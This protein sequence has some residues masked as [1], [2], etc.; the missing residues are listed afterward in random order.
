[1]RR[2][3]GRHS[4]GGDG[5]RASVRG[6]LG[7]DPAIPAGALSARVVITIDADVDRATAE[8]L[9]RWAVDHCPVTESLSR[10]VPLELEVR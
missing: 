10:A 3:A 5:C 8:A 1:V 7:L 2:I 9:A 6:I 4:R